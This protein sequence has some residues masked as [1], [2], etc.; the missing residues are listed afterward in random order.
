MPL[1]NIFV[2]SGQFANVLT[3]LSGQR[4]YME[5]ARNVMKLLPDT[6]EQEGRYTINRGDAWDYFRNNYPG[7]LHNLKITNMEDLLYQTKNM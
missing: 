4:I 6:I 5:K 7:T 2:T 3:L 1:E